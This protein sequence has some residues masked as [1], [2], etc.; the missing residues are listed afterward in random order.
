MTASTNSI[1]LKF[2]YSCDQ[3]VGEITKV[4][5]LI[6]AKYLIP[7]IDCLNLEANPRSSKTGSVTDAIQESIIND[8]ETFPFKTKG[9]LIASSRYE[10]LERGRFRITPDN[11]GIEGILDGGHN[12]LAIGLYILQ[13]AME[14]CG[15]SFPKG[16]KT[17]SQF[18]YIWQTNRELIDD[19]QE[20]IRKETLKGELN[21]YVPVEL[22]LPRDPTDLACVESFK[23]DL[24][25]ICDARN[26]NVQ[27][28]VSDKANQRG[29]YDVLKSLMDEKYPELSNKIAWKT[30]D[31]GVIKAQE[32]V[33]L[34]W[35]PLGLISTVKDNNGRIIE[36]SSPK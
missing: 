8:S 13:K 36:P 4:V 34:S 1:I 35:I 26:N 25:E 29:Y 24:L 33:A 16:Q 6:R 18:K 3:S 32:I 19:Y 10:R 22:L 9:I 30:N 31:G 12:T 11:L 20:A 7:I 14:H 27:L 15:L 23:N 5:G 2:D 28:P 17:W 21:F